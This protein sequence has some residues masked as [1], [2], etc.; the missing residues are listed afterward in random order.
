MSFWDYAGCD[1][2]VNHLFNDAM[3]NDA[4]LISSLMIE[5]CKGTFTGLESLVDVGGG[6]GTMAKAIAKSFPK[7][8]CIVLDLPHVVAG[9]QGVENLKYFGGDMFEAIPPADVILLKG[10][11]NMMKNKRI[12]RKKKQ[13]LQDEKGSGV[14]GCKSGERKREGELGGVIAGVKM[15]KNLEFKIKVNKEG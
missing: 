14:G 9:L 10:C 12:W 4:R 6:T 5:K 13:E 8:Q 11:V 3:K 15:G 1:R 2:K 7:M